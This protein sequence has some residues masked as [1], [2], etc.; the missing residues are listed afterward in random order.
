MH[1][2]F[3][4]LQ[5]LGVFYTFDKPMNF[6]NACDKPIHIILLVHT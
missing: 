6:D 2:L 5:K 1:T 4:K 3:V